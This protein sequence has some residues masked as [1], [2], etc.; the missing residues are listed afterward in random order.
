MGPQRLA[1]IPTITDTP[2]ETLVL[3][4][5]IEEKTTSN[6]KSP[7]GKTRDESYVVVIL[8]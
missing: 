6:N 4:K 5:R 3:L 1:A 8:E 7:Y 2:Q